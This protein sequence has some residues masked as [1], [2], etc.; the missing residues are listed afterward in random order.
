MDIEARAR[1]YSQNL[2]ET[3]REILSYI[4][5]HKEEVTN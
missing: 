2:S 1:A 5:E 4:L 3:D